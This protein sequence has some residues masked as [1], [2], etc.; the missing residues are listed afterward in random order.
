MDKDHSIKHYINHNIRVNVKDRI[1]IEKIISEAKQ[2][3]RTILTEIESKE[4]LQEVGI[5][6]IEAKLAQTEKEAIFLGKEMGFP[7]VLKVVSPEIT[8]KTDCGGV[9]LNLKNSNQVRKA[10]QDILSNVRK[11]YSKAKITGVSIQ[12]M[13]PQG[14]EVI[15][16][17]TKDVQFGPVLMFG[18]GGVLVE[19]LKDVSFRIVPLNKL[20]AHE[21]IEEIRGYPLLKGYRGQQPADIPSLE[22]IIL[23]LSNFVGK[24]PEIK[25]IDLNPVF[26]YKNYALAADARIILEPW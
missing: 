14:I 23:K 18:F 10:Y 13:A 9:L 11:R 6:V 3:K 22:R 26:A 19:L 20:D 16:G 12:K 5:P 25:E 8:H 21:M 24:S 15:I 17:M 4:I 1:M 2:N 7:V